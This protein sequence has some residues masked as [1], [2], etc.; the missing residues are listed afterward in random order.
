MKKAII[1]VM[2]CEQS[3]YMAEEAVIRET[4]A[5]PIINGKIE[6]VSIMFY[7]GGSETEEYDKDKCLLKLTSDDGLYKTFEKT[8]DAFKYLEKE[9]IEYDYVFRT[10]TSTY[11]NVDAIVQFLNFEDL[12]EDVMYAP[13]LVINRLSNHIPYGGGH[14]LII[15]RSLITNIFLKYVPVHLNCHIDDC[16]IGYLMGA[17]YKDKYLTEH[18]LQVDTVSSMAESYFSDLS[19]SYCVRLKDE[20]NPENNIVNMYGLHI[21]YKTLKV[22][23][24]VA[25]PHG[26]TKIET[27]YG[28]IPI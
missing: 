23:T 6:N 14:Y 19:N 13:H 2:S 10:N 7:R 20:K 8:I 18:I 25:K 27:L 24:K 3:R 16:G 28:L 11:I 5:K 26:F 15:P 22:K 9:N 4:W 21:L 1:L 17:Y 12:K